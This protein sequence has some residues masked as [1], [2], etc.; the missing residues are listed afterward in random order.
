MRTCPEISNALVVGQDRAQLGLMLF[1]RHEVS[2]TKDLLD[3]VLP[4]IHKANQASPSFAQIAPD[5]CLVITDPERA[6]ALPKSS[7][8]TVQRISAYEIY[9]T[10]IDGLYTQSSEDGDGC[11]YRGDIEGIRDRVKDFVL[12][13]TRGKRSEEGG[14]ELTTDLFAWGVDSLMA[15]RIRA[16]I[17]KVSFPL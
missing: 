7:K 12:A 1:P 13:V 5:M 2:D 8:G 4:A 3:T 10:E 6:A 11:T 17:S 9:K 15:S 14:L 16:A